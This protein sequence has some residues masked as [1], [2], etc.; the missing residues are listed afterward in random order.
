MNLTELKRKDGKSPM[1]VREKDGVPY[2]AFPAF[3]KQKGY[4]MGSPPVWGESAKA[5]LPP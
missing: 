2:L 5:V 4:A 1:G 3:E